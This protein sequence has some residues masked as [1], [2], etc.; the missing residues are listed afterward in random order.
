MLVQRAVRRG[1]QQGENNSYWMSYSDMMAALLLM[2]ILLLFLSLNRY[3]ALQETK[4]AELA[5]REELL[6]AAQAELATSQTDLATREAENSTLQA[7]LDIYRLQ[8]DEQAL[9]LISSQEDLEVSLAKLILQ[10]AQIDEQEA[11]LALSQEEIDAAKVQLEA[12]SKDLGEKE[13]RLSA[14]DAELLLEQLRVSDLETL[15]TAQKEELDAQTVLVEELVG[16]RS[17]I[18]KQLRDAFS[19]E[20]LNVTVDMQTGAITMDSTVFF[21]TDQDYLKPNGRA[22]LQEVLPVYFRTLMN[23]EN[24]EYVS[25][26]IIEGH[27][28]SNG[29]Y[30][31]NLDLSQRRAQ[32]V[33]NYCMSSEFTGLTAEEKVKLR[34]MISANGRSQS[35]LIYDENGV[36]DKAASRR[37]EIKFRLK[38]AEMID[39]LSQILSGTED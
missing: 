23:E 27:T 21:D 31:H 9:E 38:D 18:I 15:L 7:V 24:A 36:E 19:R 1:K 2:F 30:E 28:D 34:S 39:S 3:M 26:I 14:K 35:Q 29:T 32:A 5:Q 4:E 6:T 22:M 13:I 10:Q 37:V 12:Y 8:L 20:N 16:V 17:R 11:L 33:V 25:E